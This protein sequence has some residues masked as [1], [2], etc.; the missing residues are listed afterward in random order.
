M[1]DE[2][3]EI[4]TFSKQLP[5]KVFMH[6][7]GAVTKH[8]HQSLEL[9]MILDGTLQVTVDEESYELHSEDILL[10]NSNSIH[11]LQSQST[12]LIA[13]QMKP[14]LFSAFDID[15]DIVNFE[16]NSVTNPKKS[17]FQ[18]IR[19]AIAKLIETNTYRSEGTDFRNYSLAYYLLSELMD[20]FL[21]PVTREVKA[22]KKYVERLERI[23]N[24]INMHYKENFSLS[25]LAEEE[26]LSVPYLSSFF[27][28]YMGT[29]FSQFY[30]DVKLEHAMDELLNTKESM[31]TIALNNGFT[32]S[33]TFIRS[34]K[35]KYHMTPSAYRKK[36]LEQNSDM[37]FSHNLN[38]LLVEPGNYLHLLTK[39]LPGSE[40]FYASETPVKQ[41][42]LSAEHISAARPERKLHHN[43]KKLITVSRA[44]DLLNHDIQEMLKDIQSNIGYEFIKFHGIFS[45]D[46]LVCSRRNGELQFRYTLVDRALDFLLSIHLKPLVQL[47][48]MPLSL[49]SDPSKNVFAV[50]MNTSPPREIAEWN[51]LV[52]DFTR[53]LISRYGLQ[54]VLTWPFCVWNEPCTSP[55]MFGFPTPL[56]FFEFYQNTYHTVKVI[57]PEIMFGSPS[58]LY[59]ENHGEP[60]W[61]K[62]FFNW[63]RDHGCCPDFINIHYY[64]DIISPKE[65]EFFLTHA[66]TSQFPKRED[67]FGLFIGS[68]HKV[69]KDLGVNDL[70]VYMTEWNFTLSHKNL[71]NDTCFKSCYILKNLLKNYDRLN[72]FGYWCLTDLI[73]EN[74]L[75]ETLFHGGLGL[76]TM[77][78]LRKSV[79]YAFYF[80]NMLGDD[81][82]T[83]DDGYFITRKADSIQIITYNY[84]HYGALFAAGELFD[85]TET[86]RYTP[87]NMSRQLSVSLEL[88]DLENGRY[89]IKEYYVNRSYGSAFDLW[90][91]F[92]GIPLNEHDTQLLKGQ[93][94]PGFHSEYSLIKENRLAYTA[95]LEP[96]EIRFAEIRLI[97]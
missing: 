52:D 63:T 7:L 23:I 42:S 15:W 28:K 67:D 38:Y 45:D 16:C 79:F 60:V 85:I 25:D 21:T 18:G 76:Y 47:S 74:N 84:I 59:M 94:V 35:K 96:L 71:V 48:F 51:R 13:V 70:P 81:F 87:F 44:K 72:S 37:S 83:A 92:G 33:H 41:F 11:K 24:F 57:H 55:K 4:I 75:P 5:I 27:E 61:I 40:D 56:Q 50:P 2:T 34:F 66:A 93:C 14:E 20:N 65:D 17:L 22:K 64:S 26:Q 90:V 31:E 58:L 43:F 68:L 1:L 9:L 82:I 86:K 91:S 53:H 69:F 89:E 73:E 8:W 97:R 12:T 39:Y 54:E 29:S 32:E 88:E 77:N 10:I 80:A 62:Q 49:A 6:K 46:M 78:G 19:F 36:H 3:H 30:A 95:V